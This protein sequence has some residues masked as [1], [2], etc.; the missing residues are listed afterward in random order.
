MEPKAFLRLL[1]M[2]LGFSFVLSS[3][4]PS[5]R[6]LKSIKDEQFLQD[7]QGI[8]GMRG[9]GKAWEMEEG[10]KEGRMDIESQDYPGTGANNHHDPKPPGRD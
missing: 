5:S 2:F 7:F 3:S 10:F 4:V 9:D 6:T 1:L 8:M